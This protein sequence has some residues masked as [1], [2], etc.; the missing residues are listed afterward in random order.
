VVA[1]LIIVGLGAFWVL[2]TPPRPA[3]PPSTAPRAPAPEAGALEPQPTPAKQWPEDFKIDV[4]PTVAVE[5]P[6]PLVAAPDP[7]ATLEDVVG[8][9]MPAVVLIE[10]SGGRGSGFFV[11]TDTV[12]TNAHVVGNDLA[13]TVRR[14]DGGTSPA[15]VVRRA[16]AVDLAVL[17]LTVVSPTQPTIALGSARALRVGQEVF[18]IG[19]ALGTLQN[20]VTRGIV[21]ALRESGAATLVQTDAAINPGNSGGP[22]V[23][24]SGTAVGIT[25][26]GYLKAQGLNF[27]VAAEHARALL[28]G[29][30]EPVGPPPGSANTI[31]N[32]SPP[33]PEAD[34]MRTE[35]ERIYELTL[36]QAARQADY[37]DTEWKQF[38]QVCYTG[39]VVGAFTREWVALFD[40]R[41]LPDA[42]NP[43]CAAYHADFRSKAGQLR[44]R[45]MRAE[46]DARR[47]GVYPGTIRDAKA[48]NRLDDAAM[49]R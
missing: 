49:G 19:S 26:M 34:R 38:R 27:A 13:V 37:F 32:L 30:P 43:Q 24:R 28:E 14:T 29:A 41:A 18:T 45:L 11:K 7:A 4:S 6:R 48:R 22:L 33:P 16:A 42:V 47:A 12:L 9:V 44:D 46:D 40:A 8:R 21:S 25:T 1:A 39:R 23:D 17:Q 2:R 35:G 15:R 31:R 3:P 36:A 10:T 5:T 20:T